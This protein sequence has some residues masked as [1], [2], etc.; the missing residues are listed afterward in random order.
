M[1]RVVAEWVAEEGWTE[2]PDIVVE[3]P[4][5]EDHGDYAVPFCL[6]LARIARRPPKVL[7]EEL[8]ARLQADPE[9]AG[10]VEQVEVAGPGFVNLTLSP[11]ALVGAVRSLLGS[12]EDVGRGTRE[13]PLKIL[14]EYVSVNP[15]GPLHVGHGRYAAYG[16]AL[17][18]ILV[19]SGHTVT[20]EFYINDYGRQMEMFGRSVA[21]R[22]AQT[23]GLDLAV[24]EDGYQGDYV[25]GIAAAI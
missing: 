20:T 1:S 7:A 4:A 13:R 8:S 9:V 3:R 22:Y 21:A 11:S 12:G 17:H 23:L 16:N 18:R 6:Q 19:Y 10:L 24:P 15:N 14:L 25:K 2:V 5:D